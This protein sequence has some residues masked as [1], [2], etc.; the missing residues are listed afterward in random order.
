VDQRHTRGADATMELRTLG[1]LRPDRRP[2]GGVRR[3]V[4][5]S[6]L[7]AF[8]DGRPLVGLLATAG[9]APD[10]GDYLSAIYDPVRDRMVI[11][12][13]YP[14]PHDAWELTWGRDLPVAVP[15]SS[16]G[17]LGPLFAYP[18]PSRGNVTISFVLPKTSSATLRVFDVA[19]RVVR[20][21]LNETLPAGPHSAHWDRRTASGAVARPG[22]YLYELEAGGQRAARTFVLV[23]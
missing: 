5:Q 19:G 11:F 4:R 14:F 20:T 22:L 2:H 21:L 7:G 9:A 6:G 8:V 10:P 16:G 13:G 12:G 15:A 1:D 17:A 18:N 23:R 3:R